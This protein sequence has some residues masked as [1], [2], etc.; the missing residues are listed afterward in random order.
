M[1]VFGVMVAV[2]TY[3]LIQEGK[4][5]SNNSLTGQTQINNQ[6]RTIIQDE[7]AIIQTVEK[8]SPSVVAIGV[9]QR[10]SNP[11]DPFSIP[12]TR[13]S[14]IATGFVVSEKGDYCHQS[15]CS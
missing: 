4:L 13:Q 10:V 3:R 6:T 14:T 1:T 8:Y 12:K 11:F 15:S 9:T 7:N 5:P 2:F